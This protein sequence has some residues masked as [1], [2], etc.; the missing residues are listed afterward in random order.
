LNTL[1]VVIPAYNE[2]RSIVRCVERVLA[3]E[4]PDLALEILI[5]DDA[6]TDG[7]RALAESLA[8]QH[9]QVH[10]FVHEV[11]QGKGAALHTGFR[12]ATGDFV[13]VQDAD[14]EYDP[15]DLKRLVE[16]L[17]D[18][19]ADVV[20]GSR[21]LGGNPHRVLYFWHSI[22]NRFLTLLSNMFTDL[23]LTD[24]E[25]CYKV[26]RREVLQQV[27]LREKRFGFEPEIV[28]RIAR[29]RLRIYEMGVS[30]A[31]RTYAEGK[32]IGAKDGF[33]AL[34]C[35]VRYNMPHAPLPVQFA[36]YLLVGGLCA[37]ANVLLFALLA[38]VTSPW[39]AAPAAFAAAAVLNYVLCVTLL[40]RRRA[41]WSTWGEIAAYSALVVGVGGVD[42][43]TTIGLMRGGTPPILAK[44]VATLVAFAFNFLGRRFLVFREPR[45]GQWARSDAEALSPLDS[46]PIAAPLPSR[47]TIEPPIPGVVAP[48]PHVR[49]RTHVGS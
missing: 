43:L 34:Y 46:P 24:M 32:K 5:V 28:A 48:T 47:A 20:I 9:P 3:I 44:T 6:S 27:D 42:L 18:G 2:E 1:S 10:L 36:G 30:Y 17:A 7:T 14:L 31:G 8:R 4:E 49:R 26:F 25:T 16:P 13:A 45:P 22:G 21:F 23:N 15:Q 19:R 37:V 29:M 33:R 41:Q 11:N 38:R 40:F 39:V 12:R 35:V